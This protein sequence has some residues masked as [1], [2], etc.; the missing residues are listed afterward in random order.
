MIFEL[1]KMKM[2]KMI[3]KMKQNK[4]KS[5]ELDFTI[6][7]IRNMIERLGNRKKLFFLI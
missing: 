4:K 3:K 1:K 5:C 6:N 2:K 7:E